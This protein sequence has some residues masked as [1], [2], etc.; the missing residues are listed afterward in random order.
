MDWTD[1]EAH[2]T[3]LC[4]IATADADGVPAVAV[5]SAALGEGVIWMATNAN[6]RKARNLRVNPRIS[7]MWRPGSEA[8]VQGDVELLDD[9]TTRQWLWNSG[10][11]PYD[12]A[13]FFGTVDNPD[14]LVVKITPTRAVI[15]SMGPDGLFQQRWRPA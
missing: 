7:M 14:L 9:A 12:P 6:S 3:G 8:Y 1:V 13:M 15:I 5:V 2:L 11:L 10:L 4:N